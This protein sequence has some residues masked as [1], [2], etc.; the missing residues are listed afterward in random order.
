MCLC[1]NGKRSTSKHSLLNN[2]SGELTSTFR[3]VIFIPCLSY[4]R[5]RLQDGFLARVNQ[6]E[7]VMKT[8]LRDMRCKVESFKRAATDLPE[9]LVCLLPLFIAHCFTVPIVL[10]LADRGANVAR[11][12]ET[13]RFW[14]S[15][16]ALMSDGMLECMRIWESAIVILSDKRGKA[17]NYGFVFDQIRATTWMADKSHAIDWLSRHAR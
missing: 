4:R 9:H 17:E 15:A 13:V 7:S 2:W 11:Q 14:E 1:W 6:V 3:W 8:A 5:F 16:N 12:R 10:H